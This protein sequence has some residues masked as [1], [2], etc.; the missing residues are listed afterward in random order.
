[1]I[2]N[3]FLTLLTLSIP[4]RAMEHTKQLTIKDLE[5]KCKVLKEELENKPHSPWVWDPNIDNFYVIYQAKN[6]DDLTKI[7]PNCPP[8]IRIRENYS[9]LGVVTIAPHIVLQDK[10]NTIKILSDKGLKATP[11]DKELAIVEARE[12]YELLQKIYLI[13]CIYEDTNFNLSKLL[14]ELIYSIKQLFIETELLL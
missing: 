4:I 1:M 11:E 10:R 5:H 6:N 3:I 9:L 8:L 14:P 7:I 13:R 2:K 12:R